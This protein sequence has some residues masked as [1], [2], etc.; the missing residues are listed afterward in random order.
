M[1]E[2]PPPRTFRYAR[3]GEP[4]LTEDHIVRSTA[5]RAVVR[6]ELSAEGTAA[7]AKVTKEAA[8]TGGRD[9]AWHHVAVVVGDEI[10]AFPQIDYDAHPDG[11][12][13]APAI[14]IIAASEAD[15]ED[16][17]RRLQDG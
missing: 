16:L 12:A 11:I 5:R 10:V 2:Q 3:I 9:Q 8:R 17:V 6:V 15:A 1:V 13:D 4:A 14:R 7:F